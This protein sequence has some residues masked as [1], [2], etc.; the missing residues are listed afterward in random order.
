MPHV[1][2]GLLHAWID[3]ALHDDEPPTRAIVE[4]HLAGCADCRMRLEE[5]RELRDQ[6]AG[7]LAAT[8]PPGIDTA[9][10]FEHI[11]ARA[12]RMRT[13]T[14]S[15]PVRRPRATLA[16]AATLILALG[17]GWWAH[18]LISPAFDDTGAT[19]EPASTM[20]DGG[21]AEP[22]TFAA[23]SAESA[24]PA[25][26]AA[27]ATPELLAPDLIPDLIPAVELARGAAPISPELPALDLTPVMS[28]TRGPA[29]ALKPIEL[30][31]AE[32]V[33][34]RV[35]RAAAE[36]WT[37]A[38]LALAPRLAVLEIAIAELDGT[39]AARVRQELPDGS[40]LE[41]L[42]Q[43]G[44]PDL[45]GA[46]PTS[47]GL[48][49]RIIGLLGKLPDFLGGGDG[50]RQGDRR[51]SV[52]N[53]I[54][55]PGA[56]SGKPPHPSPGTPPPIP[57]IVDREHPGSTGLDRSGPARRRG[58]APRLPHRAPPDPLDGA[59]TAVKHRDGLII[60]ARALVPAD[61]LRVLLKLIP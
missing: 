58:D 35:D 2:E 23:G 29:F 14:S 40:L 30:P 32:E 15:P 8:I 28:A 10:P 37:G 51:R 22:G 5:A 13:T 59:G 41:V 44:G 18:H 42:Q 48:G 26:R 24:P 17:A 53:P 57:P 21:S 27:P 46:G 20:E 54:G 50:P 1:D 31:A 16:R 4:L 6:I 7:I 34:V 52:P 56:P 36:A 49:R 25:S 19:A 3:G 38:E 9:P 45:G 39:R 61:S 12:G 11:V 55:R 33:W 43:A 47:P 60:T